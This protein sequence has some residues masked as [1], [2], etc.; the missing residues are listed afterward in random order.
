MIMMIYLV[1]IQIIHVKYQLLKR[2]QKNN[3]KLINNNFKLYVIK[4]K[5]ILYVVQLNQ[6]ILNKYLYNII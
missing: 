2:N 4:N 5:L 1:I 3:H 6:L